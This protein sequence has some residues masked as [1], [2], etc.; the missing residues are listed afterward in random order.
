MIQYNSHI[1]Q[2]EYELVETFSE[3][4]GIYIVR[5]NN[6]IGVIRISGDN[7]LEITVPIEYDEISVLYKNT[8]LLLAKVSG[9]KRIIKV[10]PKKTVL[11]DLYDKVGPYLSYL[12]LIPVSN[13]YLVGALNKDLKEII[14]VQ[15]D[16]LDNCAFNIV[17]VG[18]THRFVLF[19]KKE[20]LWGVYNTSGDILLPFEYDD[21][22]DGIYRRIAVPHNQKNFVILPNQQV[23]GSGL[24][25]VKKD[26]KWGLVDEVRFKE[27]VPCIYKSIRQNTANKIELVKERGY[28]LLLM[29]KEGPIIKSTSTIKLEQYSKVGKYEDGFAIV[30]RDGKFGYIDEDYNEVVPCVFDEVSKFLNGKSIVKKEGNFGIID[31]NNKEIAPCVYDE[32]LQFHHGIA[33]VRVG[34]YFGAINETGKIV[35]P[36]EY[37]ILADISFIGPTM[38]VAIK[39]RLCGVIDAKNRII[40]PFEYDEVFPA[41]GMITVVKNG[42]KGV[43]NHKGQ[44][45]V[46]VEYDEIQHPF[47]T[48]TSINVC[49]K[50]KWGVINKKGQIICEPKYDEI[51]SFGFACGRLAVCRDRKWGFINW[52][53]REV[54]ECKFDKVY[55]F[56]EENHCEVKLN[57]E[58]IKID[59]YGNRLQ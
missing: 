15:Y 7:S 23:Y 37:F 4:Y 24:I 36:I 20:G 26:K 57:G 40:I 31:N 33:V 8:Y 22:N 2:N 27:V 1:W 3:K 39:D 59:V 14:P 42:K 21:I 49:Q 29:T 47:S 53:G 38:L 56:F 52:N 9:K 30:Q 48:S 51:D 17:E 13:N 45:I 41:F 12:G 55:Q 11:S 44:L 5:K 6:Q 19:M 18:S 10:S 50:G 54:I 16:I 32:I 34:K 35:I 28:D 58:K 43:F 25:P 46:P